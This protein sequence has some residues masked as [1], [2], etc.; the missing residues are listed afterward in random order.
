MNNRFEDVAIRIMRS[1]WQPSFEHGG[2][3]W[4]LITEYYHRAALWAKALQCAS[5]WP[6]FDV[7]SKVA[8][9]FSID[10]ETEKK[11]E[12][13]LSEHHLDAHTMK[14]PLLGA[15]RWA[16]LNSQAIP[17]SFNLPDPYE[18]MLLAYE[19]GSLVQIE[20]CFVD[21]GGF[22]FSLKPLSY[23]IEKE[24]L[25]TL[26]P[27]WLDQVDELAK[28]NIAAFREKYRKFF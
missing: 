25:P 22:T 27:T 28:Q 1:N 15:L 18:P 4:L 2:S 16:A 12:D 10:E 14:I 11:V 19:R 5:E 3:N 7:S 6:Y 24:P 21:V 17:T 8:P 9:K 13:F 20:H 23:Y 26:N